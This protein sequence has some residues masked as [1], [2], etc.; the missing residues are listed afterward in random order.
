MEAKNK[1]AQDLMKKELLRDGLITDP[2]NFSL[3][4]NA[5]TLKVNKKKQSE[6]LRRKYEEIIKGSMGLKLD[7]DDWNYNFNSLKVECFLDF[8]VVNLFKLILNIRKYTHI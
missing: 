2:E 4:L 3:Q 6:E 8:L 5:N 7:G 1:A